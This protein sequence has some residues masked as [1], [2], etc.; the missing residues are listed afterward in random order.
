[1]T[2][3]NIQTSD[4]TSFLLKPHHEAIINCFNFEFRDQHVN[5]SGLSEK[6]ANKELENNHFVQQEVEWKAK[7]NQKCKPLL[8]QIIADFDLKLDAKGEPIPLTDTKKSRELAG[9]LTDVYAQAVSDLNLEG[10]N[11]FAVVQ[12]LQLEEKRAGMSNVP[13]IASGKSHSHL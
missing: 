13:E 7:Q 1:M 9:A 3:A 6:A 2:F 12:N 11:S 4:L 10:F 5:F 8:S